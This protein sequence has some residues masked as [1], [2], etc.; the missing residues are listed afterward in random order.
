V[1]GDGQGRQ[2]IDIGAGHG[3]ETRAMLEQGWQ[4]LAIDPEPAAATV[5]RADAGAHAN[6]LDIVTAGVGDVHLPP[7]TL[8]W[9]GDS[10]P[11][12]G[13]ERFPAVWAQ[14]RSALTPGAV[15]AVDLWGNR[16]AWSDRAATHTRD[17]VLGLLDGLEVIQLDESVEPRRMLHEGGVRDWHAYAVLA[18]RP[19]V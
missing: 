12:V 19:G 2:A 10:L 18:R 17:E 4:V 8:I 9:A 16:H 7:A 13:Q 1:V 6:R 15:L 11:Y 14:L 5:L 3:N